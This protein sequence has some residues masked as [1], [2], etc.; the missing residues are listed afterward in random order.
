MSCHGEDGGDLT[1]SDVRIKR[2]NLVCQIM[3]GDALFFP[4]F[5]DDDTD[6]TPVGSHVG[7]SPGLG[8]N[9]CNEESILDH[10]RDLLLQAQQHGCWK[11]GVGGIGQVRANTVC[12]RRFELF[13]L[14]LTDISRNVKATNGSICRVCSA[15]T[16]SVGCSE[17][18]DRV[19]A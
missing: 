8:S 18:R 6:L 3:G 15:R 19:V 2:E 4:M 1:L 5:G 7:H 16:A 9:G 10:V 14:S 12:F 13:G 11:S 17:L